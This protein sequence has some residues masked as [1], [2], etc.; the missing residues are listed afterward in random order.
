MPL[1]ATGFALGFSPWLYHNATHGLQGLVR[2]REV[3][4][5]TGG[6]G[7]L[8]ISLANFGP[9]LA[10]LLSAREAVGLPAAG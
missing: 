5:G 3:F 8:R 9:S 6:A 2:T 7:Q 1:F 4:A 10:D